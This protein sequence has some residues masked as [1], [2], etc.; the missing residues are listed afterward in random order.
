MGFKRYFLFFC[1]FAFLKRTL[2]MIKTSKFPLHIL[3]FGLILTTQLHAQTIAIQFAAT[4]SPTPSVSKAVL[5]YDKDFAYS[6][7][8]DDATNDA[9]TTALPVLKGGVVR[10]NGASFSGLFCTD[11]CGNNVPFRAGIAWNTANQLG[12][13]VHT[14]N[15]SDQL[16]W[17]QL[18]TLYDEGWDVMNHSFSHKSRWVHPT[19]T[20]T[21]YTNEVEQNSVA[22]R[23]KT[24][25]RLEMP[26]FVVPANDDAYHPYAFAAGHK[27]LFDQSASTTGYGG[28]RVDGTPNLY[29]LKIHRMYLND[30]YQ[31]TVPQFIDTVALKSRNGEKRWF[32]E[33]S[34]RVDDF[35]TT[36]TSYNF[37]YF[38][39]HLESIANQYG[40]AGTDR[41]WMAPLQE[42]YEY[43]VVG[44]TANYT[45]QLVGNRM[46]V[47]FDIRQIPT[48][49]RRKAVTLVVNSTTDFTSVTVPAGVKMTFKGTGTQKI[50][51]LDF[52]GYVVGTN[53]LKEDPSVL[54]LFPNPVKGILTVDVDTKIVGT[55]QA[56]I[57]DISGKVMRQ[58]TFDNPKFQLSTADLADGI[59]FLV[60]RQGNQIYREK[61]VKQAN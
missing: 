35:S 16:T 17:G 2:M 47:T 5:R 57:W 28:L 52:S 32:N 44:Q 61:F 3:A 60:V 39:A 45:S 13:D 51:N 18:D 10:A 8:L 7:T 15:V 38:K 4:P 26:V 54:T 23:N 11:G 41:M 19:M 29:Q 42:V 55:L 30:V 49:V 21:D 12:V 6:F 27:I 58:Q 20:A 33:F 22:V 9:W 24:K 14:G 50:I 34:H 25:K 53:D 56:S 37:Y 36:T 1:T 31:R 48:W 43:L 46:D 40:K 59:Y